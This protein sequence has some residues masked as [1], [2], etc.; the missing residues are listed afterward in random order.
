MPSAGFASSSMPGCIPSWTPGAAACLTR[1]PPPPPPAFGF[2]LSTC[3]YAVGSTL[4]SAAAQKLPFIVPCMLPATQ[5]HIHLT[6][7]NAV[8]R[9]HGRGFALHLTAALCCH[10]CPA[11]AAGLLALLPKTAV[12]LRAGCMDDDDPGSTATHMAR[13]FPQLPALKPLPTGF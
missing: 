7:L 11:R 10:S 6:G 12:S 8:S 4:A 2:I 9:T 1:T 3:F 13:R 5:Q